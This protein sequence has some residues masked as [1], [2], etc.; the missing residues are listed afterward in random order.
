[1]DKTPT[2]DTGSSRERTRAALIET[3]LRLF[4]QYGFDATS[5]RM[6]AAEAKANIGSIAYHFGGK[7]G[8]RDACAQHIVGM[9]QGVA[10]PLL[11][12]AATAAKDRDAATALLHRVLD[13]MI[14]FIVADPQAGL[15]VQFVLREMTLPTPALDIVYAGVFEPVHRTLCE[16]W[17][18]ATGAEPES[19]ATRIDVFTM[20]GQVVYFR[21]GREAVLRRM[22]WQ[23]IGP[24][25]ASAIVAAARRNLDAAIAARR[26]DR[27]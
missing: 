6:I 8:L 12:A 10:T 20:I 21:V 13:R 7:E 3:G 15:V 17:A 4:G 14:R 26:K 27:P 18:G 22:E 25:E 19:E 16:L 23:A 24:E 2:R 5:T 1:M 9:V 11:A